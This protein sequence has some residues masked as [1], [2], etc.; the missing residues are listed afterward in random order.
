MRRG[1][2]SSIARQVKLACGQVS[3]DGC[4]TVR[5][6]TAPEMFSAAN[7]GDWKGTI[8]L[9]S[10]QQGGVFNM[11][12]Q[13]VHSDTQADEQ[14]EAAPGLAPGRLASQ[15][16]FR[17][18][19]HPLGRLSDHVASVMAFDFSDAP[20]SVRQISIR[21]QGL[22]SAYSTSD[23][24]A[25][26][27]STVMFARTAQSQRDFWVVASDGHVIQGQNWLG[28]RCAN[29]PPCINSLHMLAGHVYTIT[30]FDAAGAQIGRFHVVLRQGMLTANLLDREH[31]LFAR[32]LRLNRPLSE[33]EG[34]A[35]VLLS[36]N[37]PLCLGGLDCIHQVTLE[38][39]G[40][41]G[42]CYTSQT[43]DSATVFKAAQA[44]LTLPDLPVGVRVVAARGMVRLR[45][46]GHAQFLTEQ[47]L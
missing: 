26:G 17:V 16:D 13:R 36:W 31:E 2:R 37:M 45:G 8:A 24:Q 41:D 35:P 28:R 4:P 20:A 43:D 42:Q 33:L 5:P 6:F 39:T 7:G 30:S 22:Q 29:L 10:N 1:R 14:A 3:E 15:Q 27:A 46:S 21:G 23:V 38:L 9:V 18:R 34:R 19:I 40:S 44:V 25:L 47:A 12:S 11:V 32:Q